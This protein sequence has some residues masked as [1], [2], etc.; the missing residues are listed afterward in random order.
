[1]AWHGE[2]L[3]PE[4]DREGQHVGT[5]LFV[6]VERKTLLELRIV[7]QRL[8]TVD[9]GDREVLL[10][11]QPEPLLGALR[12]EDLA[13]LAL[14][15]PIAPGVVSVL[16][17]RPLFEKIH[18]LHAF[19]KIF[20]ECLLRTHEEDMAVSGIV[21]LIADALLH[22]GGAWRTTFEV[23]GLVARHHVLGPLVR[24]PA[25]RP[26]PVHVG[27][28]VGL[29][30]F[31]K[32]AFA[33]FPGAE[34][35]G[36]DAQRPKDGTCM[37]PDRRVLDDVAEALFVVGRTD[38]AGPG[39]E[40]DPV[41]RQVLVWARHPVTRDVAED[42]LRID[43]LEVVVAETPACKRAGP[44]RLHDD[45]GVL[46]KV[47][48]DLD[49]LGLA[50]IEADAPLAP[51]D[52]HVHQRDAFDDGP[53]HLADV[54]TGGGLDLDDVGTHVGQVGRDGGRGEHGALDH[55]DSGQGGTCVGHAGFLWIEPV[56][57]GGG[58]NYL[59]WR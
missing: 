20:P 53:G 1:M 58:E 24:E 47:F 14:E 37:D 10:I 2:L 46:H 3:L 50:Q 44:H 52:V 9:W 30:E 15:F 16:R 35:P 36:Q 4:L 11:S 28:S 27:C 33:G 26:I 43:L 45:V 22:A 12:L 17:S 42:D 21:H 32:A 55:P 6:S 39:V 38:D 49:A 8:R 56:L 54:V 7:D 34:E 13:Q 5:V 29:T 40:G 57:R 59:H 31:E 51:V 23:V 25:L 41:G 48:V 19:A 18:A